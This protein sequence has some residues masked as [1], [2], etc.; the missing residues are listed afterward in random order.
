MKEERDRGP[1]TWLFTI[2]IHEYVSRLYC[3][4]LDAPGQLGRRCHGE[5][6]RHHQRADADQ[7]PDG[8]RVAAVQIEDQ[9][10]D[11]GADDARGDG[12]AL[13]KAQDFSDGAGAEHNAADSAPHGNEAAEAN[14]ETE[15]EGESRPHRLAAH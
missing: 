15:R 9:A 10:H 11:D 13:E 5:R 1:W 2:T 8:S 12:R 4:F 7:S 6:Q 14:A 3:L